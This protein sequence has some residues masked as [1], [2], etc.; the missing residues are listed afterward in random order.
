[1]FKFSRFRWAPLTLSASALLAL[2][3]SDGESASSQDPVS[4]HDGNDTGEG[5]EEPVLSE[6][7]AFE[8]SLP[9]G[10]SA[11]GPGVGQDGAAEGVSND[12]AGEPAPGAVPPTAN[13]PT[14]GTPVS[15]TTPADDGGSAARAIEEA[16][17][18]KLDGDRL[19]ALSQ[20][21]GLSVIDVSDPANLSLLGRHK[22]LATP[23]EM[24]VRENIAMVLYN[25]YGEYTYDEATQM[26]TWHQTSYVI[27]FDATDPSNIEE[28]GRFPVLGYVSDSRIVGD[29]LYVAAFED[30]YCWGCGAAPRTNLIS[31]DVSN[32]SAIN[33]VDE[34]SFE[35][36]E[37]TYGWKKSMTSTDQRMYIA[38]PAWGA[39]EQPE[40]S[41]IQVVDISDPSGD[42]VLGAGVEVGGQIESRWQMDEYEGVLRVI[43][44]PFTWST[45]QVPVIETFDVAASDTIT[46]LASL[47]MVLPRP[48]RL[49]SVRFD[50]PRG[51]AITFQQTDPLFT[52]DLSDPLAPIQAGELE[53][54]GWVY[55]MHPHGDR[56]LGLGFDQ[57]NTDGGLT[58]SLFDVSDLAT[59]TM[60]SRVNFGG[61]WGQLAEDQDRIHKAF[62]V[63]DEQNLILVP[64]SGWSYSESVD[65]TGYYCGVSDYESGVQLIDWDDA[66]DTLALRAAA[67]ARGQARR[68]FMHNDVLFTMSDDRL[69]TFDIQDR[70][71][72]ASQDTLALAQQVNRAAGDG[73]TLVK[74]GYDWWTNSAEI[75]TTRLANANDLEVGA[76]LELPQLNE[77][78]CY[79]SS[80]LSDV[81]SGDGA[82][83]FLYQNYSY[84]PATGESKDSSRVVTVDTSD[85]DAPRL[86]GDA[87]LPFSP[88]Y[89]YGYAPGLVSNGVGLVSRGNTL[90]FSNHEYSYDTLGNYES[91]S[92]SAKVV[93]M[94]DPADPAVANV[95]LPL[96]LGATGLL[97]DDNV[98]ALSHYAQSPTNP[99]RVRFYLDR[100]DISDAANPV[101]SPSVNIP[102]SLLAYDAASERAITVDYRE[103]TVTTTERRCY[104]NEHGWFELPGNDYTNY[105]PET[106]P[107][108]C[109]S[110]MQ[111]L[112]LVDVEDGVAEIIDSY[113]LAKGESVGLTALGNDRFFVALNTSGGYYY[114][115]TPGVPVADIAVGPGGYY[116]YSS[117]S[118]GA[119]RLLVLGGIESGEFAASRIELETGDGFYGY[120]SHLVAVGQSAVVSTGWQGRLSVVD[121]SDATAPTIAQDVEIAGY[122]Q[123]LDVIGNVAVASM[124]YD[125]VQTIRVGN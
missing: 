15:P 24:Y 123:D 40:G 3:C 13:G 87:A 85:P 9:G 73:E 106:T 93:D 94:S 82:T 21:G 52:I 75:T 66:A 27:A 7:G 113:A 125:G 32:P 45:E 107:G 5:S 124:G 105:N 98:V 77:S 8:S 117:F 78:N 38:G 95:P 112:R 115:N 50:G 36:V 101:L 28:L 80:Y 42:M 69:E 4:E 41:L 74:V 119:A 121:G 48:E 83:Y 89:Y 49:Q 65:A 47:P 120:F 99:E 118:T 30:G 22:V 14:T 88:S 63:L 111:T 6:D 26:Y 44:Q 76:E 18:I 62:N 86:A 37:N 59:P 110:V 20:Y 57:G 67:P 17:I 33:K 91:E 84:N 68:G 104:E 108:L 1:M 100:I 102:G 53:M 114:Y 31:L 46:P 97:I 103:V 29:I 92:L 71:A 16:D 72:P 96:G 116:G 79:G 122:V 56:V 90:V 55:Y 109:H 34:L 58:V 25:G 81:V 60:L 2:A 19:F 39:T 70:D 64:F 61:E 12:S 43:S 11:S 23:F 10:G 51:Y 54:P 35:E